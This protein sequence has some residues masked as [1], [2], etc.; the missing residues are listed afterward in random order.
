MENK[1]IKIFI[2]FIANNF[3]IPKI[4]A[5]LQNCVFPVQLVFTFTYDF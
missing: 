5:K 1:L 3:V 2:Y 4:N